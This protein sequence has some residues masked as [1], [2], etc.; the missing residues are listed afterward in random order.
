MIYLSSSSRAPDLPRHLEDA[1]ERGFLHLRRHRVA[2]VDAGEATLRAEA[3]ALE[4]HIFHRLLD[5][6]AQDGLVLDRL[7][8]GGD[9]TEDGRLRLRHVAQRAEIAGARRGGGGGG[10][11]G[12]RGGGRPGR[13]RRI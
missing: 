8:L 2:G 6:V 4:R 1:R 10:G 9:E 5:L 11:G 7:A 13:G 12:G 3:E